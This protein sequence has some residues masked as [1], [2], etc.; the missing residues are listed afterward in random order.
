MCNAATSCTT[1]SSKL[2]VPEQLVLNFGIFS[3]HLS[4]LDEQGEGF[5]GVSVMEFKVLWVAKNNSEN[6]V[7][8]YHLMVK[9]PCPCPCPLDGQK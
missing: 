5:S 8:W 2:I 4:N 3:N 1:H 6:N 7:V 9:P